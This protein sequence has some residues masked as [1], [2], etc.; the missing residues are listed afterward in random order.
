MLLAD[1]VVAVS[2]HTKRSIVVDYAIPAEKISVVHN[3]IEAASLLPAEP[4]NSYKYLADMKTAGWQ[5]VAN[6]GRLTIQKGLPHLLGAAAEVIKHEPKTL[7]LIVGSGEL[8]DELLERAS[9]LGIAAN[10]IFA[11]FQRGKHWRDAYTIADLFVMPSVSEPFGLTPLEAAGYGAPVLISKQSGVSEVLFNC[12]KVDF[13]DEHE[14]ANQIVAA[15]RWSG[16]RQQLRESAGDEYQLLSWG[17]AA[18]KLMDLYR[19]HH[20]RLTHA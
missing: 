8:R 4:D 5:V 17:K 12:L 14:M 13:W 18:D 2:E 10:V 15:L 7:F 11:G 20:E 6:I 1:Q 19:Q 9:E 16:L 3:S